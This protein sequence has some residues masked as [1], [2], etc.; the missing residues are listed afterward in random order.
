MS[1]I[2]SLSGPWAQVLKPAISGSAH[3]TRMIQDLQSLT[4]EETHILSSM[5]SDGKGCDVTM[6]STPLYSPTGVML[7]KSRNHLG[8]IMMSSRKMF[9]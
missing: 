2:S 4:P 5:V 7:T 1:V 9:L 3:D 8:P 6:E